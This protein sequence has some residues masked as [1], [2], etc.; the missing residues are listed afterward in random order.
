MQCIA[1]TKKGHQCTRKAYGNDKFCSQHRDMGRELVEEIRQYLNESGKRGFT[2][3]LV[4]K[5][6]VG[7]SSI[8][9]SLA[10]RDIAR[11][12]HFEPTTFE[13]QKY[14]VNSDEIP[15]TFVDTPGLCDDL[16]EVGNDQRYLQMIRDEVPKID[17]LLYVTKI[18]ETR[19]ALD[20][21][22]AIQLLSKA[23]SQEADIWSNSVINYTFAN[24]YRKETTGLDYEEF[25]QKRTDVIR[26]EISEYFDKAESI[27][28]VALDNKCDTTPDGERWKGEF[29]T[30][31][32]ERISEEGTSAF[33]QA[34][35]SRFEKELNEQQSERVN[36]KL[37]HIFEASEY[38]VGGAI[39]TMTPALAIGDPITIAVSAFLGGIS[40]FLTWLKSG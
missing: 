1:I 14:D 35:H 29:Y 7:K 12:G 27:P 31:L 20:E 9:N 16:S 5:T 38:I 26:E 21:K 39:A 2:C 11:V 17:L 3:L 23:F 40:G 10:G 36:T 32:L 30:V 37:S 19:L 34:E 18:D 22:R 8:I 13:I 6:G 24:N 15:I 4:G 28:Y 25:L 33:F